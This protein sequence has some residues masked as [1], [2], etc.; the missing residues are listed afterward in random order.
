MTG[1]L[2]SRVLWPARG[3]ACTA[4]S[5]P[6]LVLRLHA[7]CPTLLLHQQVQEELDRLRR[8]YEAWN[9]QFREQMRETQAA[10]RRRQSGAGGAGGPLSAAAAAAPAGPVRSA[11]SSDAGVSPVA[12]APVDLRRMPDLT[13][14]NLLSSD[15]GS[16]SGG[17]TSNGV[18]AEG[19]KKKKTGLFRGLLK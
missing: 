8:K 17:A 2:C 6:L 1:Q 15:G 7:R 3:I 14:P 16:S 11:G 9:R 18:P 10:L 19:P 12:A 4:A 13:A 5:K